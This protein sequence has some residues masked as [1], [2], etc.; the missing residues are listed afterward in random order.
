MY[1]RTGTCHA[2]ECN[3][4]CACAHSACKY[5]IY[6][7]MRIHA[8]PSCKNGQTYVHR[9]YR[10]YHS[11]IHVADRGVVVAMEVGEDGAAGPSLGAPNVEESSVERSRR[12]PTSS[13]SPTLNSSSHNSSARFLTRTPRAPPACNRIRIARGI[14]RMR[15]PSLVV[16]CSP[17]FLHPASASLLV[18]HFPSPHRYHSASSMVQPIGMKGCHILATDVSIY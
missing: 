7:I 17:L 4:D 13:R 10:L 6:I 16:Y 15:I 18:V 12:L 14:M 9:S 11:E 5:A 8:P 2:Q 3:V 1:V